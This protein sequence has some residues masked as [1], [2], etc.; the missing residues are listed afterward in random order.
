MKII[1]SAAAVTTIPAQARLASLRRET[2]TS[3]VCMG[4]TSNFDQLASRL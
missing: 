3:I 4:T 1:V 2:G